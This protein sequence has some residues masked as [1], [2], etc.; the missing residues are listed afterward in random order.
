ME[1]ILTR[2]P[3][4]GEQ[5][6]DQLNGEDLQ[7]CR[8][9]EES[10]NI[11]IDRQKF[12]WIRAIQ[13]HLKLDKDWKKV[14]QTSDVEIVRNLASAVYDHYQGNLL[15]GKVNIDN[16]SG[17]LSYRFIRNSVK[18]PLKY[19]FWYKSLRKNATLNS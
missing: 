11:F 8:E 19:G 16:C 9:I 14:V 17:Q 10:W 13:K 7:K 15:K 6:F 18:F 2:F 3:H 1:E 12:P 4:L 5:I